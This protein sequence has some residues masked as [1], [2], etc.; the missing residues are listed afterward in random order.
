MGSIRGSIRVL[1]ILPRFQ[2]CFCPERLLKVR[3]AIRAYGAQQFYRDEAYRFCLF[4]I[5]PFVLSGLLGG[6]KGVVEGFAGGCRRVLEGFWGEFSAREWR[7]GA[8]GS[9][10]VFRV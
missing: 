9:F 1:P 6:L 4:W 2:Q 5:L 10:K 8:A 7:F 3:C